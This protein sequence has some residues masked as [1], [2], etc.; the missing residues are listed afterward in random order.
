MA[1][2]T[3]LCDPDGLVV[4]QRI[5]P[6]SNHSVQPPK[7]P[8]DSPD[9]D[10]TALKRARPNSDDDDDDS[11]D[12]KV[13]D[14]PNLY[15]IAWIAALSIEAAAATAMLDE[16]HGQPKGFCR[17]PKDDNVYEWG[18]MGEHNVVITSLPAGIY[19]TT[20]ASTTTSKLLSSLP[21]IKIGLMVGIGGGIARPD[22]GRD[23]RLG[24]VVI[25]QPDGTTGGVCQ[26]DLFKAKSGDVHERKGFLLPPP[27][28][29]L[30]AVAAIQRWHHRK[31]SR[32]PAIL[33]K[34]LKN[35]PP[36]AKDTRLKP[37]FVYQGVANDQLFNP[38]STHA[39]GRDCSGCRSDETIERADRDSTDPEFHY[40][41]IASGNILVKD[42]AARDR[43]VKDVGE[44]CL[45]VEMEA[46]GLMNN[47]PC[48]VVRG[49][50]DYAD[51]HKNDRWQPY[52]SATAAAYAKELLGRIPP[53]EIERTK[54][55]V[56]LLNSEIKE[57]VQAT[58]RNVSNLLT[59]TCIQKLS[60]AKGAAFDAQANEHD[61]RCHP[62]TR[63]ELLADI[64]KWIKDPNGKCIFWLRG[65]AGTGKSTISRTVAK[66]LYAAKVPS[67][68]FF[69][70]QG[71]GDRGGSA[72]FFTTILA[73][74]VHQVPDL[75]LHV[76]NA[77]DSDPAII[78]KAKKEQF[79]RLLLEP[80]NKCKGPSFQLLAVVVDALDECDR[81][82]DATALIHLLSRAQEATSFRL[83]FFV[84]SRPELPI[85]LGFRDI[86]GDYQDL[87]LHE[88]P[89]VDIAKDISTF[90]RSEL[91]KIREK[92]N[93][94]VVGS[95]ISTD[96]PSFTNLQSLVNMA[97]PLFIFASTACR[98]IGDDRLGD[99]ENQLDK[100]LKY[101]KKGGRSQLH[102]TYLPILD[103]LLKDAD[104][105]ADEAAI[106]EWFRE[107]V[108]AI[109]LL[110]DPLSTTSLARLLGKSQKYVGLKLVRLHSVLN[111]S[112]DPT[113]PVKPLHL[114]FHGFLVDDDTHSFWIDK[115][116]IHKR[117]A[118]R[119][120]E[121]L[122]TGDTLRKDVC[123]LH[124]PGT[125]RSEIKPGI[126]DNR[127]PPEV[128]YACRY[129]V[130]HWKESRRQIRDGDPVHLFLTDRLLYWLEALGIMGRIRES[131]NMANCLLDM[132]EPE[133]STATSALLHDLQRF[134]LANATVID[135]SPLQTYHS[136]LLFAPE[137]SVIRR[138][139][140]T[141]HSTCISLLSPVNLDWNA[142]LQTL[143][144]H[145]DMVV[146]VTFSPDGQRLASASFDE[147]VKLWDAATGACLTT[148][149]GHSNWVTSVAFSPDGQRLASASS[150]KTVKLWDAA[151]GACLKTFEGHSNSVRSVAFSPDGQRLASASFDETVKLWDTATGACLTTFEGHSNLVR[152]VAFS[153]DGQRLASASF[154]NTK[155]WDA[156]TGAC[157]QTLKWHGPVDFIAFSPDGQRL[158]S[159]SRNDTVKLWDAA[160]GACL[161]TFEGSTSALSFDETG[162]YLQTDFGT[163]L[164]HKQSAAGTAAVQAHS[165]HRDFEGI[166]IS[167][168]RAWIT[169]KGKHF[170]WLPTEYRPNQ[171]GV[172]IAGLTITLG[173]ASGRVLFFQWS[174]AS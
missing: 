37:G 48:L 158:A 61:P 153:P 144:G 122:S 102:Q 24:D 121:L 27:T 29:L 115:Q 15:T 4:P 82:E 53:A 113:T 18:R 55:A 146:S 76:R 124:H 123:D 60:V 19:G 112:E 58:E 118:N 44:D 111:I 69:F 16:E 156:A 54:K 31:G 67:A 99:P 89:E 22:D 39:K 71:E 40:G 9:R 49:I 79:E 130:H 20:S 25:S 125:L 94:T 100:L 149:E 133:N 10:V 174:G 101:R 107:L 73:Q 46:A 5:K 92:F 91:G 127:L 140:R 172:A 30:N 68:S 33:R 117:L 110:A 141:N 70:K 166:G 103:Q 13:L 129:W 139:Q 21:G 165:Q 34:M 126:I 155:L 108:G 106:L 154:D 62:N 119:C 143:E 56:E 97:V 104:T 93:K 81:E 38:T 45:C 6:S 162:S 52:A 23:I 3:G 163:K 151:T 145:S 47:F 169:W 8:R 7:R 88:I 167:V 28:V 80:L 95:T 171:S 87:S 160:T 148:L 150:D 170:L 147:T 42:A 59:Q 64:Y 109:V 105:K 41:I 32:V 128:Q 134:L 51:S 78:D 114:S 159:A 72:M 26:Y 84:T 74:L 12:C 14:S 83:R 77:I 66:K 168:D 50:C 75:E 98:F 173:C 135:V 132:L 120:L 157:L 63:V 136:A 43:I 2:T 152:S 96:W 90:L 65:M 11:M 142:C 86:S 35:N 17:H 137:R 1:S 131:F 57:V 36:M 85:R 164:L 161:T 116:D 138:L